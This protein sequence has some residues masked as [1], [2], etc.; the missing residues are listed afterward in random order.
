MLRLKVINELLNVWGVN[1]FVWSLEVC[2]VLEKAEKETVEHM[3][4]LVVGWTK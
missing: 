1:N 4:L 3:Y 2:K